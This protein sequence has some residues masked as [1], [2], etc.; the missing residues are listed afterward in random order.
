MYYQL[1]PDIS[2]SNSQRS[3]PYRRSLDSPT[4]TMPRYELVKGLSS[5]YGRKL[6]SFYAVDEELYNMPFFNFE[7]K[8]KKSYKPQNF[9]ER[10]QFFWGK[11][12]QTVLTPYI[13]N[14]RILLNKYL[15]KEGLSL[16]E[17]PYKRVNS[18]YSMQK[19]QFTS[20][21]QMELL[22]TPIKIKTKRTNLMNK[23]FENPR[24]KS[25]FNDLKQDFRRKSTYYS[26]EGEMTKK[27][28]KFYRLFVG[29]NKVMG[30]ICSIDLQEKVTK[31]P[32][33]SFSKKEVISSQKNS[34]NRVKLA[35]MGYAKNKPNEKKLNFLLN[36]KDEKDTPYLE[37]KENLNK[38]EPE[39]ILQQNYE[40][41][42][43]NNTETMTF[44]LEKPTVH[45]KFFIKKKDDLNEN[46][47]SPF[48]LNPR[49]TMP[50]LTPTPMEFQILERKKTEVLIDQKKPSQNKDFETIIRKINGNHKKNYD[51]NNN[52]RLNN[53]SNSSLWM[54]CSELNGLKDYKKRMFASFE[55]E[56]I[57][58]RKKICL[59]EEKY[60]RLQGNKKKIEE[61]QKSLEKE[62]RKMLCFDKM[63]KRE[64]IKSSRQIAR[65]LYGF[66]KT[67]E[68]KSKLFNLA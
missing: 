30:S 49:K 12:T 27:Q 47:K 10:S 44:E 14:N 31:T 52:Y 9:S 60:N 5:N 40:E 39:P 53:Y 32:S 38:N 51:L 55:E 35:M 64:E 66:D 57:K 50:H 25:S 29:N 24:N 65:E 8:R 33:L 63:P 3:L 42:M 28:E 15:G 45:S 16:K 43:K 58:K 6:S 54:D 23:S 21:T 19:F 67:K 7:D 59:N 36:N 68:K 37:I 11:I 26:L 46:D 34:F 17:T 22:S 41:I 56:K 48:I 13:P 18:P 61:I 1:D 2:S 20:N 62:S 4:Q